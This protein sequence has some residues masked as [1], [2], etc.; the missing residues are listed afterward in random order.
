MNISSSQ[1]RRLQTLWGLFCR[2]ENFDAT[3]REA[4]LSWASGVIGRQ[5]CSFKEM[6]AD[7]AA[8]AIDAM[9]KNLPAELV[10]RKRPS[11]RAAHALGTSGRRGRNEK[12]VRLVDAD[13]LR[14]LDALVGK[15]GWSCDRFEAFLR[16]KSSPV[17]SGAIHTL[18][19]ANRAIWAVKNM[20]RAKASA[21]DAATLKRAG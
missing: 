7:E 16:G 14:L 5:I 18:A 19:E 11:R 3:D 12:E 17:K 13:T 10:T 1:L 21:A 4:R 2:Q 15:L 9:Q 8:K 6:S 20:L